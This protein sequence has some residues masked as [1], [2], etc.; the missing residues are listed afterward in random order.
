MAVRGEHGDAVDMN[1][2]QVTSVDALMTLQAAIWHIGWVRLKCLGG[3]LQCMER[4]D[5]HCRIK[6]SLLSCFSEPAETH[7]GINAKS[8]YIKCI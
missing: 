8:L 2:G 5:S 3:T 7:G 1:D 4:C 6:L